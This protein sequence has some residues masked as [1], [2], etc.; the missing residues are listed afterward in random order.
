MIKSHQPTIF[1]GEIIA[2]VSSVQDGPMTKRARPAGVSEADIDTSRKRFL[3]QNGMTLT[4]ATIVLV[5]YDTDNFA[6]YHEVTSEEKGNVLNPEPA[7]ALVTT[8][9][10]Q[11]LFLP[12]A[13]CIGAVLY[14]PAQKVLMV[15]HLG[16]QATEMHGATKSVQYLVENYGVRPENIRV[17]MSPAVGKTTYPLH[18]F[19]NMSLHEVNY[20]HFT[21]AGILPAHIEVVEVDTAMND[22]YYSHSQYLKGRSEKQGRFAIVA[23]MPMRAQGE[24][25]PTQ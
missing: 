3:Q 11:A 16:R 20:K 22:D 12:L 2:A 6:R 25:A 18:A 17:W 19:D 21:A 8:Q 10:G 15:S 4:Q 23:M 1:A 24:S 14:D 5:D 7:D 9:P 13:D